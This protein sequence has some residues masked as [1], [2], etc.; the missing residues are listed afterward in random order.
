MTINMMHRMDGAHLSKYLI[1]AMVRVVN[2]GYA[3]VSVFDM[4][5]GYRH[6]ILI[7]Q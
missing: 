6:I 3:S 2:S 7:L 5:P 1:S 4:R